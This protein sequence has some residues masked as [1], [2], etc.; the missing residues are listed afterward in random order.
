M[1]AGVKSEA[2]Q[3]HQLAQSDGPR[4][5]RACSHSRSAAGPAIAICVPSVPARWAHLGASQWATF[6]PLRV[7]GG[8]K[9][10]HQCSCYAGFCGT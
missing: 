2:S 10:V 6:C 9:I 3:G 4:G 1:P 5:P 8:T 7:P